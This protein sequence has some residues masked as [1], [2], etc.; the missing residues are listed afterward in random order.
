[1]VRQTDRQMNVDNKPRSGR[2]LFLPIGFRA[3]VYRALCYSVSPAPQ[4]PAFLSPWPPGAAAQWGKPRVTRT[5]LYI[6]LVLFTW[7]RK[8]LSL[9]LLLAAPFGSILSLGLLRNEILHSHPHC[10]LGYNLEPSDLPVV[11]MAFGSTCAGKG[12]PCWKLF[13]DVASIFKKI[14]F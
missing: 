2:T 7:I 11:A 4:S 9:L 5:Y 1:M 12:L 6:S 10:S 14:F 8:E 3:S 13:S